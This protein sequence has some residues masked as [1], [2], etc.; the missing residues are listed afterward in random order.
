MMKNDELYTEEEKVFFTTLEDEVERG[1]YT[2]LTEKKLEIEAS[3]FQEVAINTIK[4]K[5]KKKS[6][7]LR[8]FEEDIE[9]IKVRA[10]EEGIPYQ[11]LISAVIHKLAMKQI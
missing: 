1:E 2:P 9:K 4:K 7:N 5:T 3:F 11:T 6:L 8:V 10:L